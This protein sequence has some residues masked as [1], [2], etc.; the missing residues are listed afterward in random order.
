M[1]SVPADS[2]GAGFADASL[3]ADD[4]AKQIPGFIEPFR[5]HPGSTVRLAKDFD[6][7]FKSGI[8]KKKKDGD[9]LL[10]ADIELLSE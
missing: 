10:Q 9:D 4:I 1:L 5:V 8:E 7:G 3:M 2:S 6:P